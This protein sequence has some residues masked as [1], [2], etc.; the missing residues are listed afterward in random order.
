M[1]FVKSLVY[2]DNQKKSSIS[3]KKNKNIGAIFVTS[4]RVY[5]VADYLIQQKIKV[6]LVGYDLI[7]ENISLLAIRSLP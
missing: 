7:E 2:W 4:S 1:L 3:K 6:R 5:L